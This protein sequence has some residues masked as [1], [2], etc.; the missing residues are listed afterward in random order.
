LQSGFQ[1][2][3]I[4]G[5]ILQH[6]QLIGQRKHSNALVGLELFLH[7]LEHLP[8]GIG[9]IAKWCVGCIQQK[10]G[11]WPAFA[12]IFGLVRVDTRGERQGRGHF[13]R[14]FR[15]GECGDLLLFAVLLD[16]EV[17]GLESCD[18]FTLLI[19]HHNIY[20][21]HSRVYA[22]RGRR[23]TAVRLLSDDAIED[24]GARE[25]EYCQQPPQ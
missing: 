16:H 23:N 25:H 2:V 14:V 4:S 17:L 8:A 21:D 13:G 18:R 1:K 11:D 9:L 15:R 5:E 24:H 12:A 19:D 7:V 10:H 20:Q 3:G 22:D 6:P